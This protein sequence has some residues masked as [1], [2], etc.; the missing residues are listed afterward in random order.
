MSNESSSKKLCCGC[1]KNQGWESCAAS[2]AAVASVYSSQDTL[3]FQTVN[4]PFAVW[5]EETGGLYIPD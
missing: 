2:S 3:G 1:V 4:M 5:M